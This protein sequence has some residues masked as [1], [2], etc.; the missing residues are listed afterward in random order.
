MLKAFQLDGRVAVVTGGGQG[1]GA[2]IARTLAQGG[3]R[4]V[5]FDLNAV[6]GQATADAIRGAGGEARHVA[7]DVSR[8]TEVA[9]AVRQVT[10]QIGPPAILVNNAGAYSIVPTLEL[11][12]RDIEPVMAV[13]Y[14]GTFHCC[15]AILP[16]MVSVE[17]GRIVS[18][19]SVAGI[20]GTA[21]DSS[22]YAASK[23]AVIALTR[24]LAKEFGPRG[25]TVNAVAPGQIN[26]PMARARTERDPDY[27]P[28]FL[29]SLPL[30]RVGEPEDVAHAVAFLASDAASYITGQVLPVCGGYLMA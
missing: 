12:D 3:A 19:A 22:H 23:A 20:A 11:E 15:R 16:E 30:R 1:I 17:Y 28:K 26:A 5:I 10:Q 14:L 2:A 7:V 8:F 4:V 6:T 9:D 13:N 29:Q 27:L 18:I 25:I 21:R 24:S